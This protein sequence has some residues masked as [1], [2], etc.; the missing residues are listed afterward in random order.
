MATG[1]GGAVTI[2]HT[3]SG[4]VSTLSNIETAQFTDGM[5][6]LINPNNTAPANLQLS[7]STVSEDA[8]VD[9]VI[10]TLNENGGVGTIRL[11]VT[12]NTSAS[13]AIVQQ[14]V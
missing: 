1:A 12:F 8:D 13:R 5:V 9:T 6:E 11:V 3:A 7:A 2:T 14:L 10:G 4:A